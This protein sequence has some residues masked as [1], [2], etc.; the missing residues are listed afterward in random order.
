MPTRGASTSEAPG[1][2]LV[3]VTKSDTVNDPNGPFRGFYILVAGTLKVTTAANTDRTFASGELAQG[4]PH[5]IRIKRVWSTG[6]AATVSG[7][8]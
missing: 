4:V 1:Y 2:D 3:P 6:S 8:V 5:P 7:I